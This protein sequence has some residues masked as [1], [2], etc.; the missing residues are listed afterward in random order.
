MRLAVDSLY[1][2]DPSGNLTSFD[3]DVKSRE[4]A[5]SLLKVRGQLKGTNLEIVSKG[6]VPILNQNVSYPYEPRAVV[7]NML[8]PLDRLPGLHVGQKWDSR[9]INPFSGQIDDVRADVTRRALINW[10]GN[11]INTFEVVQRVGPITMRTWVGTDGVIL[12]QELPFPFVRLVL[13]RRPE[14]EIAP[15]VP[16]PRVPSS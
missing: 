13:E 8:G 7:H 2:V 12:R 15:T 11:P 10:D 3:L 14:G 5:D 6:P 16:E 4:P 9:V 1:R